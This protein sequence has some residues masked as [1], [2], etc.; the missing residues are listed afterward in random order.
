MPSVRSKYWFEIMEHG[1]S[2]T[3]RVQ[4]RRQDPQ[5][6]IRQDTQHIDITA[7]SPESAQAEWDT[8]QLLNRAHFYTGRGEF[9]A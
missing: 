4:C 3:A 8:R 7:A 6:G 1:E 9:H 5:S 2:E